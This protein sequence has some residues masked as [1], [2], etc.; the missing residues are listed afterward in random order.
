MSTDSAGVRVIGRE[1]SAWR[2][3]ARAQRWA[4]ATIERRGG[5]AS[6]RA[7]VRAMVAGDRGGVEPSAAQRFRDAG[8]AHVLAVSGLH[9]AATALLFFVAVRR[10]WAAVP[11]LAL[12][13]D[14]TRAA[15]M[16]AAPAAVAYAAMTGARPSTLRALV[17][18]LCVLGGA[19]LRRR[20]RLLDSLGFAAIAL[21][22]VSPAALFDPGFQL[23]FVATAT[24]AV[25]AVSGRRLWSAMRATLWV[26]LA[27]AP[28]AAATFGAL[29]TGGVF[30][31]LVAVPAAALLILP[32]GLAGLALSTVWQAGGGALID[33]AI[34]AAG[35][36][37]GF[38]SWVAGV[39]PVLRISPLSSFELA[40]AAA[41]IGLF[42]LRTRRAA[43]LALVPAVALAISYAAPRA[44]DG[45]RVTFLDVGQGD[46]AVVE[47]P[48]G[49][50]WLIDAGGRPFVG[51]ETVDRARQM[52]APGERSV[53]R[54]L[55]HRRVR[56]LDLVVLSHPHPDHYVGL[57]AI[58]REVSIGEVWVAAGTD[59]RDTLDG[60][61][62]V[63]PPLGRARVRAGAALDVLAPRYEA[64]AAQADPV[65]DIN[66]NSL[67]V[68]LRFGGRRVLFAGDLEAEGEELLIAALARSRGSLATDVVKVAHHGSGTSSTPAFVAATEARFAVISCGRANRFGFPAPAVEA[69]WREHGARV[70]RT[71]RDGAV[72][73]RIGAGGRIAVSTF[74]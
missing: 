57:R 27:T 49:E 50:V 47:L 26:T 6:G 19:A 61:R 10:L 40:A 71:D 53:L 70:F 22:V 14:A 21:L 5:A 16:C 24:L 64:G 46:A 48:D 54:F 62:V 41:A 8:I 74:D 23:S 36:L 2:A 63:H 52:E 66:D 67:V 15:A 20:P 42:V 59:Y 56:H 17:V 65:Y 7:I 51:D 30:A 18:V 68:A 31:N 32:V 73:V 1:R 58:A 34:A 25:V 72:T 11:A 39:F 38:A 12:R 9:L 37:D 55:A 45:V 3:P 35:A 29:Q 43:L 60:M 13:A 33:V 4:S 44:P 28:I 69:R